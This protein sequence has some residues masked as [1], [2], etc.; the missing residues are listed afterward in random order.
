[1]IEFIYQTLAQ[2]GFTHPLHPTL[3]HVPIGMVIGA[4]LFALA[5][6]IFRWTSLAQTARHCI[7]LAALVMLPTALLG[8][9]DWQHFYGG[10]MLF[11]I[12]MKFILA[13]VLL[14]FLILAVI[15]GLLG[16]NSTRVVLALHL[17][18][19][20]AAIGLGYF[21]GELVYATKAHAA[22]ETDDSVTQG[23]A[24]FQQ[25]CSACHLTDS[26]ASKVGPGLKGVFKRDKFE[27]SGKEATEENFRKQLVKPFS[28]MPPFGHLT[29]EQVDA[30]VA[31]SKTL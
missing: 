23:A 21:G 24:V 4:F 20:P 1:M 8:I 28:K 9:M 30:L 16:K 27:V 5:A 7:I 15:F 19:L 25:N 6:A 10:A 11:P 3:T 13:G 17:L 26:T 31:Y 12:K 2:L 29:P 18:C 22:G 14:F